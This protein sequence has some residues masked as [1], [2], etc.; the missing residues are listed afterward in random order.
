MLPI[1]ICEAVPKDAAE[2]LAYTKRI[3]G[4]SDNLSYG[5]EGLPLSVEQEQAF[6]Q[7]MNKE[8]CSAFFCARIDGMLVGTGNISGLRRR[9]SHRA[10]LAVSVDKSYW[11]CGI[12][13][14][15][16]NRLIAYATE[17]G[18]ELLHLEVRKDNSRAI[19]LY[20]KFGFQT[21]GVFPAFFKVKEEY[22]D[23][24]LMVLDLR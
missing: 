15:L 24:L 9:M 10:E 4:Q 18:I 1:E 11:D 5:E 12:G 21:I 6:L 7:A 22:V 17:N 23:F 2:I 14:L 19:H 13:T 3:G 20:K 8:R 16:M